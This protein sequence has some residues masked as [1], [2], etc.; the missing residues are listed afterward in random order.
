[1]SYGEISHRRNLQ[2]PAHFESSLLLLGI[3]QVEHQNVEKRK[4]CREG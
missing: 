1:M 2:D 4:D 3:R